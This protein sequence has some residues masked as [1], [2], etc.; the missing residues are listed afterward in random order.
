MLMENKSTNS[1]FKNNPAIYKNYI[2]GLE[3]IFP[4]Q[5]KGTVPFYFLNTLKS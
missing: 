4:S 2:A 1:E 3:V 5:R